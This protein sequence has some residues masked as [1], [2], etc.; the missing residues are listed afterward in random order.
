[1]KRFLRITK[2]AAY[3]TYDDGETPAAIH[4]RLSAT[5]AFGMMHT[6]EFWTIQEGSGLG[7]PALS[8][9]QTMTVSGNLVTELG[10]TLAAFLV[11]WAATRIN[12]AQTAPWETTELPR[13]LASCTF[14]Y[15]RSVF[16]STTLKRKRYLGVKCSSLGL[17]CSRDQP[18]LMATFGCL[19]GIVQ[20]NHYD[21]S[22]DPDATAFPEPTCADYPPDTYLFQQLKGN[23]SILGTARTNFDS[24]SLQLQN[25]LKPYFDE[26]HFANAIRLVGRTLTVTLRC[27]LKLTPDDWSAYEQGTV[28]AA[29]FK[30]TGGG[31]SLEFAMKGKN[32][33]SQIQEEAPIDDEHY[34]SI[35][36]TNQLDPSD[37]SDFAVN[38]T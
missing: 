10:H 22:T 30:F 8:G 38:I 18:K 19:G 1:M 29:S 2:E 14:D 6:P 35:T 34:Y 9:T 36:L 16:N 21:S 24:F 25:Q 27:R 13:D 37:C 28:G 20:G 7:V 12:D 31:H 23:V 11:P 5:G 3:N 17:A 32:Y 15:A 26:D 33:I 4:P